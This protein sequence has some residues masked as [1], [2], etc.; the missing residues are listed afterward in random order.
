[1]RTRIGIRLSG[2]FAVGVITALTLMGDARAIVPVQQSPFEITGEVDGLYPGVVKMLDARVTNPQP[3]TIRVTSAGANV[4]DASPGCLASM[5]EVAGS[6]TAVDVPP[7]ATGTVPLKMRMD[8]GAPD[9]CQSVT[10][11]LVFTA[12]A[13]DVDSGGTSGGPITIAPGSLAFTG[14]NLVALVAIATGL[15]AGGLL[16]ARHSRRRRGRV[17]L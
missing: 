13:V 14:A 10:F 11:P 8:R 12:T 15:V 6:T 17:T 7:G 3:F 2:T 9:A 1:M 16:A 4:G 5:L